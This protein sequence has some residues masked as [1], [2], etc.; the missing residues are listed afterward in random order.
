[1]P[2]A[3]DRAGTDRAVYTVGDAAHFLGVVALVNS[4]RLTGWTDE[5]VVVDCGLT[6]EQRALLAA[7]T[8]VLQAPEGIAPY[9]LKTVGPLTRPAA[10]VAVVDADVI[11][12]RPLDSL[13]AEAERSGRLL[14]VADV[15]S[16][17]F[18]ARWG[19]LLELGDLR[20][21]PYVNS[22]FLVAP[23]EVAR[24]VLTELE[25]VQRLIDLERSMIGVGTPDDPF[26]FPDQDA[27]NALL[28]S[29][30]C[31]A[32]T[33]LVL[34]HAT[35]PHPPFSGLR[36][37]DEQSLHV[38]DVSGQQP[39]ALHHIQRKPWLHHVPSTPY[40]ELL[41]RLWLADDLRLRLDPSHVPLRFRAGLAGALASRYTMQRLRVS[42]AR[43][44][45]GI[46]RPSR[47]ALSRRGEGPA[48]R[49]GSGEGEAFW[50]R[51]ESLAAAAPTVN[52]LL[53]HRL[54]SFE[55][56]RLR[57]LGHP[58][59][60][61]LAQYELAGLAAVGAAEPVLRAARDAYDGSMLLFKGYEV[62]LRYPEPWLR[63]FT[64]VDLLVDD[65]QRA[66]AALLAAGF[67]EVGEPEVFRNIH[68]LRPLRQPGLP[69]AVEL[70]SV[71]KWPDGFAPP[72]AQELLAAGVPSRSAVDG[73]L[74][75]PDDVHAV[76]LAAHAW[77]HR[78]FRRLLDLVDVAVVAET[79]DR[80]VLELS[81][82]AAGI[83]RIWSATIRA[84]DAVLDGSVASGAVLLWARHLRQTRE[85]SVFESH[86]ERLLS[87]FWCQSAFPA[88]A[89][90]GTRIVHELV[91]AEGETWGEKAERARRAARNA[92]VSR[93]V[94][95]LELGAAANRRRRRRAG[96][97][98]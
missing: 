76:V 24:H 90:L 13:L 25:R 16:D 70:H 58:V 95:D 6:A 56:R 73:I 1:M 71:P 47:A 5:I 63:P 59:P 19:G 2:S 23:F 34:D 38:A 18:D 29:S 81:A 35:A 44:A 43:R 83:Q 61:E 54:Q 87:P 94:H 57:Q 48:T 22:G 17:R 26:Y 93:T 50:P 46:R 9:L 86:L 88:L 74:A 72:D 40:S 20:S 3:G 53:S 41:P 42:R 97:R 79:C 8:I 82:K 96:T 45:L 77:A 36:V 49:P 85:R 62:A 92:F 55:I 69:L 12:T 32:D 51:V 78:P 30:L 64:D 68:H 75:L 21:H 98:T 67:V 7:E 31:A 84:T 60:V 11:V 91:P 89:E 28:G 80:R 52:D 39:F 10:L 27:L 37:V 66:Q 4:L 33:L 14:A 65:P 15:L